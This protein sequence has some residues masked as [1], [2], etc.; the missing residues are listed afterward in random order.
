MTNNDKA[1]SIKT[2]EELSLEQLINAFNWANAEDRDY[3]GCEENAF[4]EQIR[5]QIVVR[6]DMVIEPSRA[7][8]APFYVYSKKEELNTFHTFNGYKPKTMIFYNNFCELEL[9]R[10]AY[11]LDVLEEDKKWIYDST[12][13]RIQSTCFGGFCPTGECFEASIAVLRF[14]ATVFPD[15][16]EWITMYLKNI[17]ETILSG[18][19]KI[20]YQT[21]LYFALT[22]CEI[23]TEES[24]RYLGMLAQCIQNLGI[25]VTRGNI[26]Y[27]TINKQIM[28]KCTV[29][30]REQSIAK[31]TKENERYQRQMRNRL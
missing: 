19:K 15:E 23:D 24:R 21:K 17:T 18:N 6:Q 1:H 30:L 29:L 13:Q 10:I 3:V 12:K 25:C 5:K 8:I 28:K 14:V 27:R 7:Y 2:A 11:L 20:S 16:T 9:L 4:C 31:E 22:L 26:Q